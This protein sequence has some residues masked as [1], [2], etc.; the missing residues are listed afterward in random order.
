MVWARI[1]SIVRGLLRRSVFEREM[2]EELAFHL[3]ARTNELVTRF[4]LTHEEALRRAR[5][6]FGSTERYKEESRQT[7][8]LQFLD[9][10]RSDLKFA[11]RMLSRNRGLAC[12]AILSLALGIGANTVVF[13]VINGLLLR[14]LPVE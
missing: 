14:P 12:I 9:E 5:I 13:S 3:E 4:D 6:E 2:T 11:L 1:R 10:L 8:G 7:R